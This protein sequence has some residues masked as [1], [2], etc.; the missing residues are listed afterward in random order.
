[1]RCF[2]AIDIDDNIRARIDDLQRQMRQKT[3][4]DRPDVK[5][6]Q[7]DL[8]HLTLKFLGEDVLRNSLVI[9][10]GKIKLAEIIESENI[11]RPELLEDI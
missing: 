2:I 8:I 5:W 11:V 6:V 1:M 4:L 9:S 7:P 3:G 10:G